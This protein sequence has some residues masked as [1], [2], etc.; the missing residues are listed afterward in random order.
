MAEEG[1]TKSGAAVVVAVLGVPVGVVL[2]VV[3]L[4]S[5]G[6]AVAA[7]CAPGAPGSVG[8]LVAG[9]MPAEYLPLV[10]RAGTVCPA[11]GAATGYLAPDG[12]LWQVPAYPR[13]SS[14]WTPRW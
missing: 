12:R 6:S 9:G 4:L 13:R 1:S 2:L 11:P 10:Q 8:A 7:A 14:S 3:L 5:G